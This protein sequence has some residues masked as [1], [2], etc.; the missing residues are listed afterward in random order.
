MY[1]V[2]HN[3]L[4]TLQLYSFNEN[5]L[6]TAQCCPVGMVWTA[7]FSG[8][9]KSSAM[10]FR[11]VESRKETALAH[12]S[13]IERWKGPVMTRTVRASQNFASTQ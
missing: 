11:R 6:E 13:D 8:A 9:S 10:P 4:K 3:F 1:D 12:Q 5:D 7:F 2:L